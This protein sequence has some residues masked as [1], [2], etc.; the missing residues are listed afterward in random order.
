MKKKEK[1]KIKKRRVKEE[2]GNTTLY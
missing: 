2:I 1:L